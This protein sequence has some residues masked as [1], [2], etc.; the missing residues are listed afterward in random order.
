MLYPDIIYPH[1][2][3]G[4]EGVGE[5]GQA[6]VVAA[7]EFYL[8]LAAEIV[9]VI[10]TTLAL[11]A[12]RKHTDDLHTDERLEAVRSFINSGG[13]VA[14]LT[15]LASWPTVFGVAFDDINEFVNVF[16]T[17]REGYLFNKFGPGYFSR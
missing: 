3:L 17:E 10:G 7:D 11:P 2:L 1:G 13:S 15:F 12:R 6:D 9:A 8:L 4:Y 16:V 5:R 14:H